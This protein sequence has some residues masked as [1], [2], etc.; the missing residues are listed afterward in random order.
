MKKLKKELRNKVVF[1]GEINSINLEIIYK[2]FYELKNKVNY[3]IVGSKIK[4][5]KYLNKI[6]KNN[7][8]IN[9][10]T[11]PFDFRLNH[12]CLNFY[13]LSYEKN[14]F[15]ELD[16]QLKICNYI[17]NSTK[18][19]LVTMPIDKS[20]FKKKINFIGITEYLGELNKV[21]TF[22]LMKGE[23]FSIIPLTT[24]INIDQLGHEVNIK[25]IKKFFNKFIP[26]YKKNI[27]IY[28]FDKLK[29]ICVNPHCGEEGLLDKRDLNIRKLIKQLPIKI[30]GPFPS[31]SVFTKETKNTLYFSGYHDQALIPFKIL[32]K[33]SCN[34]TIGLKYRRLSPAHGPAKDIIFKNVS[35]NR[36][37]VKCMTI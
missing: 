32:N 28:N 20:I 12:N 24:H 27:D 5:E 4:I 14:K 3:Y 8:A 10:I 16:K 37:Y 31:D 34:I 25:N 7:I 23:N 1:L 19:D 11:D 13:D 22:M 36:S 2:S 33:S 6:N 26:W 35:N 29:F 15:D 21:Q 9:Y 30:L 18:N 17:C